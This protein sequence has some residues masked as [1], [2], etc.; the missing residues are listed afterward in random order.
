MAYRPSP[1]VITD[2]DLSMS[3][4]LEASTETPAITAPEVSFT[5]PEIVLCADAQNEESNT[6][7]TP[8]TMRAADLAGVIPISLPLAYHPEAALYGGRQYS[9][10]PAVSRGVRGSLGGGVHRRSGKVRQGIRAA[11]ASLRSA[12][13]YREFR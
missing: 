12:P 9:R 13:G 4:S 11:A 7:A 3:A 1:L 8:A 6:R 2:R 10:R 5:W